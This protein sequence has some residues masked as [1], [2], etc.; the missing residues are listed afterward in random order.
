[1]D[2]RELYISMIENDWILDEKIKKNFIE[3]LNTT[4]SSLIL[5]YICDYIDKYFI[6]KNRIIEKWLLNNYEKF[7]RISMDINWIIFRK[8]REYEEIQ[9]KEEIEKLDIN[10]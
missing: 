8:A 3:L 2:K 9:R 4:K 1:M 5:W 7:D 10:F 6:E